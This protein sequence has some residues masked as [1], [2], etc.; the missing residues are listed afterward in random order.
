[1]S[2]SMQG[3]VALVTGASSGLGRATAKRLAAEGA[4]VALVALPGSELDSAAA[5]CAST[6]V[7]VLAIGADVG[8][9]AEVES[10]FE[11]A[12]QLGRVD[13]VFNN[14]G[15]SDLAPVEHMTD[16]QWARVIRV[17]L[18]GCFYVARAAARTMIGNGGGSIVN[19]AS[20]MAFVGELGGYTAYAA[21][22]GGVLA[23]TRVLAAELAPHGI[24][25]NAL[26]PGA[27]DTPM[28]ASEFAAA[29]DP[30]K[31]RIDTI[32][33]IPLG[34]TAHP[35]EIANVAVFLMSQEAS[36][37]TGAGWLADGG[38]TASGS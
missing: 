15:I 14:A 26:C 38:H 7:A 33:R 23:M 37:V 21:T 30:E 27:M 18:T 31:D 17:N 20:D 1:M 35:D 8:A 24:R 4:S 12:A 13:A 5:E 6:G 36:F 19:T 11:Q 16:E 22:K 34:R 29:P 2:G 25:V 3:R 28:L 32:R 10:A 9:S